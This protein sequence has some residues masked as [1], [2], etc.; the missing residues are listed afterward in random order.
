MYLYMYMYNTSGSLSD[1][2]NPNNF[3][4]SS[5]VFENKSTRVPSKEISSRIVFL[6]HSS[7]VS[8]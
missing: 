8:A 5:H 4:P 6:S 2:G 1:L 3:S 7:N